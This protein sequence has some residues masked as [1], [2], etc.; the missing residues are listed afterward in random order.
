[1]TTCG[2]VSWAAAKVKITQ[3]EEFFAREEEFRIISLW[4]DLNS[5]VYNSIVY[6]REYRQEPAS[7]FPSAPSRMESDLMSR[8]M[9]PCE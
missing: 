6:S 2:L 9:T 5:R 1:M 4:N 7:T 8:W 3:K